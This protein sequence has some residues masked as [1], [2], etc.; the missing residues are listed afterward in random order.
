MLRVEKSDTAL[1]LI[2]ERGREYTVHELVTPGICPVASSSDIL[3]AT[4]FDG[5]RSQVVS[6]MFGANPYAGEPEAAYFARLVG[7][8]GPAIEEYEQTPKCTRG[9]VVRLKAGEV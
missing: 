9:K 7:W 1:V 4:Y 3:V 6:M 8:F 2:S 5:N